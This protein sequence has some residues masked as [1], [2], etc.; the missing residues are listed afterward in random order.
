M[1]HVLRRTGDP[2]VNN[3]N[4]QIRASQD[5]KHWSYLGTVFPAILIWL[6]N[7][8]PGITNIWAPDVSY[9]KG[10]YQ[11]F[12]AGSTFGSNSSMIALVTNKTLNPKSEMYHWVDR[13][14]VLNSSLVLDSNCLNSS[15]VKTYLVP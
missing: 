7:Q 9:Y 6:T 1:S 11:L 12:Y 10:H 15:A 4:I 13:G 3:G 5:L 2:N 8:V 14:M